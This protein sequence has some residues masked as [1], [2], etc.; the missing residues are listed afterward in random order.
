MDIR[1]PLQE[2][3]DVFGDMPPPN[4][5]ATHDVLVDVLPQKDK[6]HIGTPPRNTD[7]LQ[8]EVKF[9]TENKLA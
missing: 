1:S 3:Q 9:L 5:V 7:I 2:F 6:H 8:K 4:P